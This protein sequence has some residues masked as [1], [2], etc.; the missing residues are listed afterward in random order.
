MTPYRG[1]PIDE[2]DLG[3]MR[4]KRR[5]TRKQL[6]Q[7]MLDMGIP[8][9]YQEGDIS[10][11]QEKL[12]WEGQRLKS[13]RSDPG[14]EFLEVS[15]GGSHEGDEGMDRAGMNMKHEAGAE[16]EGGDG[17]G[18]AAATESLMQNDTNGRY[19]AHPPLSTRWKSDEC[20]N[21]NKLLLKD[22]TEDGEPSEGSQ[23]AK[24]S[25]GV[26]GKRPFDAFAKKQSP[27]QRKKFV[28]FDKST[29]SLFPPQY[30]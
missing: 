2:S 29:F 14:M 3:I 17:L 30:L 8:L 23:F 15:S 13:E 11:T 19:S 25:E 20:E 21:V 18:S 6:E 16:Q 7:G 28:F 24:Q 5:D 12:G 27:S 22:G 10:L 9:N 26:L 4:K 1:V